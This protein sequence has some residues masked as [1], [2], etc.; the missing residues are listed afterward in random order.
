M[1]KLP[2]L[3]PRSEPARGRAAARL[4]VCVPESPRSEVQTLESTLA[5]DMLYSQTGGT[6]TG[7]KRTERQTHAER[8]CQ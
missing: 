8:D 5:C 4:P 2:C 6:Q 1:P 3:Q 7:D